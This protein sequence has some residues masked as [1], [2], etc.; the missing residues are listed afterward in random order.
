M[1]KRLVTG[2]ASL[3]ISALSQSV[4]SYPFYSEPNSYVVYNVQERES[5]FTSKELVIVGLASL[6]VYRE[7]RG[8]MRKQ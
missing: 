7:I 5:D 8:P 4:L 6:L 3:L 1:K 2:L